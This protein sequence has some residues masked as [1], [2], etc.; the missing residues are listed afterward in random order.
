MTFYFTSDTHYSHRNVLTYTVR[1]FKS[2][3]SMVG[4]A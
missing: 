1:P 2:P 3:S 4:T